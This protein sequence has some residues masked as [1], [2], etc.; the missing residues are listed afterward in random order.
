MELVA[1]YADTRPVETYADRRVFI[2]GKQNSGLRAGLRAAVLGAPDRHRLAESGQAL[3]QHPLAGRDPG[4][5]RPA[6]RGPRPGRRRRHPRRLDRGR[7]SAG[8]AAPGSSSGPDRRTVARR[9]SSRPTRSSPRPASSTPLRDLPGPRG[10]DL[11]PEPA[12][13]PD[14]VLGERD[15]CPGSSS[16]G[17]IG[18]GSK[19]LQKHG[20]PA[21]S[22]AVHGAR[23]NARC[24]AG[25]SPGPASGSSRSVRRSRRRTSS[26]SSPPSSP[27]GPRSGTSGRTSPGSSASIRRPGSATRGSARWRRS[28]TRPGR[29][30]LAITLETDGSGD[31][32]PVL[33][34]RVDGRLAEHRLDAHP[35]LDYETEDGPAR[36]STS[37]LAGFGAGVR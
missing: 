10:R 29:D 21:N 36:R 33:Y 24:L 28:S 5:L 11:R 6:V 25:T 27:A 4:A 19:G 34:R 15:R 26:T 30:A 14:A 8:P 23:Y 37:V 12:A 16:P 13:G 7:S 32:Y 3:G 31:V 9:W 1:H 22:G 35:L 17:T 2:I 20:I 18:Q